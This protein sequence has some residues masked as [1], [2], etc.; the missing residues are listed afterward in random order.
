MKRNARTITSSVLGLAIGAS[1]LITVGFGATPVSAEDPG[2]DCAEYSADHFTADVDRLNP[3][4]VRPIF[5][6]DDPGDLPVCPYT[7]SFSLHDGD[8]DLVAASWASMTFIE[9]ETES[10][11]GA[12][13]YLMPYEGCEW[14]LRYSIEE[15]LPI[16]LDSVDICISLD[17]DVLAEPLVPIRPIA[18]W[19]QSVLTPRLF[20]R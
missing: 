20:S 18:P 12:F 1:A 19:W 16:V 13:K 5:T 4:I 8:G 7:V 17:L 14:E 2:V 11:A 9:S 10:A 6:Y 3:Y 15:S